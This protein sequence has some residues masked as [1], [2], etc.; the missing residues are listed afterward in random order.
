MR[1]FIFILSLLITIGFTWA[2]NNQI[3]NTPLPPLGKVLNPFTGFWQNSFSDDFTVDSLAVKGV[4]ETVQVAYDNRLVPHI[5]AQND[6]DL[7]YVQGYITA[8]HRLF[9]MDLI[10]RKTA[11]RLS[12]IIG[13]RKLEDD[14]LAR[15]KGM[16]WAAQNTLNAWKKS[17]EE[18][19]KL[20]AFVKGINA[21]IN[22]LQPKD[23]P[24]EYKLMNFAPE[25]WTEL[26]TALFSKEMARTLSSREFDRAS[27]NA[28]S[29]L[30]RETFDF[31][32]PEYNPKQS[33]IIPE[34]VKWDFSPLTGSTVDTLDGMSLAPRRPY[35]NEYEGIG[36]NNWAVAGQKTASGFPILCNDPHLKLT[37]PSIWFEIQLHSPNQNTY[38]VSLPGMPGV[39]LG[40]NQD[41]AWGF[42]NVGQDVL[43]WYAIDW[44]EANKKSYFLD[45]KIKKIDEVIEAFN[46]KGI[47]VVYDTVKYTV[48]GPIVYESKDTDSK[49][50]AMKWLPHMEPNID[51]LSAFSKL[52]KAKNYDDY[53]N[54]LQ[55]YST[56]AQNM[57]FA[58]KQGDIA[59]KVQGLFPIKNKE[60]GRFVQDG[61]KSSNDWKGFIPKEQIP[62]VKNPERGFVASANQHS[63][64]PDYP[65]YYNGN[66]DDYRGRILNRILSKMDK[67]TKEDMMALQ[68]NNFSIKAEEA[69]PQL[70]KY[71]NTS[72]LD[73]TDQ[74][75]YNELKKW[76]YKYT[77]EGRSPILFEE[78]FDAFYRNTWDELTKYSQKMEFLQVEDWRTIALLT[79]QPEHSFFDNKS[80]KPIETAKEIAHQSFKEM[81]NIVQNLEIDNDGSLDWYKYRS[82]SIQH[83]LGIPAFSRSNIKAGGSANSLNAIR[84]NKTALDGWGPSWRMI[85]AFEEGE[86]EAYG[87]Y[88][89]GQSGD[90]VSPFYDNMIDDWAAG[91]YYK[92]HFVKSIEDLG[93][94]TLHVE[95]WTPQ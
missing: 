41:V 66:F 45:G 77:S 83:L 33:P 35:E 30:G 61:S 3:P 40:F 85:V 21:Y 48:W 81:S 46:V 25:P 63:T 87:I 8:K 76:D 32:Y 16:V 71:V 80:T 23:Y 52:N 22:S 50:L 49:D 19:P 59:L 65:Y 70:I 84:G 62:A 64:S 69:L 75:F 44:A 20:Q 11:G 15:R 27:T 12:E 86:V 90:P 78:W 42:T 92:L 13:E 51:E 47:G 94:H 38:G 14:K 37:L 82:A 53:A 1:S 39:M 60:Q 4:Q 10:T 74:V 55:Y 58:S 72:D 88:P 57:V 26:K 5:F 73:E 91:E 36:S 31:L 95:T 43:D 28:L 79:D 67:I 2:L 17:E 34:E 6:I 93:D 89:G 7:Y 54:A 29:V 24:L 18:Y 9:Q 68:N 56:P